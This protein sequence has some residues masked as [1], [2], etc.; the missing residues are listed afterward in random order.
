MILSEKKKK[1][2]IKKVILKEQYYLKA[3]EDGTYRLKIVCLGK[4][5]FLKRLSLLLQGE[6]LLLL[7]FC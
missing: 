2:N 5:T 1:S 3:A 7:A 4:L 6:K